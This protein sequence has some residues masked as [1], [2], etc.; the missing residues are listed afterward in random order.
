ME[1]F[2]ADLCI[3][4][5]GPAGIELARAFL[6]TCHRVLLLESGGLDPGSYEEPEQRLD[7]LGKPIR[8]DGRVYQFGGTS[9][10]WSGKWRRLEPIDFRR[11]DWV[12]HS[13]WPLSYRELLP[14]YRKVA[15]AQG[16]EDDFRSGR[17]GVFRHSLYVKQHPPF[18]F[19][20]TYGRL[21][22]ASNVK[23]LCRSTVTRLVLAG[24][25]VKEL[26]FRHRGR[27]HRARARFFVLAAGGLGNPRL[28]LA[29]GVENANLGRFYMDHPKGNVGLVA[30]AE[31]HPLHELL[32]ESG[33]RLHFRLDDERQKEQSNLNHAFYLEPKPGLRETLRNVLQYGS[34][35][36][37]LRRLG[38]ALAAARLGLGLLKL[39]LWSVLQFLNNVVWGRPEAP[40]VYQVRCYFEQ[41][42]T[43]ESRVWLKAQGDLAVEW[44][45]SEADQRSRYRFL[46]EVRRAL[47]E[48]GLGPRA[49]EP[50]LGHISLLKDASHYSG[51]TRMAGGPEEGVVD[52]HGRVFGVD[53]LYV[54]G[55]SVF[56]TVG[57]GNP[58]FTILALVQR[59][60][61][62]LRERLQESFEPGG[63]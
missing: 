21:D 1:E 4:G 20:S 7:C 47:A 58:T 33:Y 40:L 39:S 3:V 28:L 10:A 44:R 9:N 6:P 41:S 55:S 36:L 45:V 24:D 52:A 15:Q 26:E 17:L 5:A 23:V 50:A 61:E 38:E 14:Y 34:R 63:S 13:G 2:E 8:R 30:V 46:S 29:S 56:P 18:N 60:A 16:F 19:G 12:E 35:A 48:A 11:R 62:H 49:M 22:Q 27:L 53:N 32:E 57:H 37:Q 42:P 25:E 43:Q 59:M 51:T 54:A 31:S